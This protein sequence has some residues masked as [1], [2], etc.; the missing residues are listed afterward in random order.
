[1]GIFFGGSAQALQ[2]GL[3]FLSRFKNDSKA[4]FN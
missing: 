1:M 4:G 2:G 3:R